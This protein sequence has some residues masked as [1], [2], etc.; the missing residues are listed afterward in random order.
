MYLTR[1]EEAVFDGES[2]RAAQKS[3]EIIVAL[4]EIYDADKLIEAKSAQIA[5]VSYHNIGDAGLEFLELFAE[6]GKAKVLATTNPAGMDLK[7]WRKQGIADS[8]A[9]KQL[10]IINAF[11]KMRISPSCTC[12]PYIAG[13]LPKFGEHVAWS[14][15]S[16]VA[17]AN[18]VIGARTNREGGPS[19]L[20]SALTGKTANYGLHLQ[21][22]R[23]AEVAVNVKTPLKGTS[24]FG[25]LGWCI[26]R[27]IKNGIPYITGVKSASLEELKSLSAS[28]ATYGGTA[29]FH[30]GGITPERTGRPKE[31]T[32]IYR[33]DIEDAYE[34]LNDSET[35]D[36]ISIGCP[37][38]SLNEL[39]KV[40][41]LL[42]GKKTRTE[43][44]VTTSRDVKK[45]SDKIGYTKIIEK[46]GGRI[47]CDT[48]VAVAPLEGRFGCMA[49]DSAKN[50]YYA[51]GSNN[52][53][54]RFGELKTCIDAAVSGEWR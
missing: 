42:R 50:C 41:E 39:R 21:E 38:C 27:E 40:S 23:N 33:G 20:A 31:R 47:A 2:G 29:I 10:R 26:G 48:C 51:K 28:I 14:E 9:R 19:A 24:D 15:S 16:A 25:A 22:N 1:E 8:F 18:S 52:F 35:P 46:A 30:I 45:L 53:K 34:S 43:L 32:T 4:G 7:N 17:Y 54:T 37:H 12:T 5:G 6:D 44:W 49:T 13:N 11:K 36:F 3:M